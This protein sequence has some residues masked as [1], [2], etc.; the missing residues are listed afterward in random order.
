MGAF[1]PPKQKKIVIVEDE[2]DVAQMYEEMMRASGYVVVK[3]FTSI[4]AISIIQAE[5]PAVVILDLMMPGVSG[6]EVLRFMRRE[7]RLM[8][9]PVVIV[10]ARDTASDI[11]AGLEA[12]ASAYLTKPVGYAELLETIGRVIHDAEAVQK[13]LDGET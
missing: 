9:I 2:P 5:M 7:P 3:S 1:M 10:S 13:R 11:K 8:N 6:M 12:G 4:S